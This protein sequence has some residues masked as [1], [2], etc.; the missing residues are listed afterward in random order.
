MNI[1]E[2]GLILSE[3]MSKISIDPAAGAQK[4]VENMDEYEEVHVDRLTPAELVEFSRY[5]EPALISSLVEQ[6]LIDRLAAAHDAR[7]NTML[8]MFA[9]NGF[10]DCIRLFLEH[11]PQ[12]QET[13]LDSQNDEGNTPLH[14]ACISGQL[15]TCKLLLAAGA[16]VAIEN[17]AERTPICEAHKHQRSTML[18][19][20]EET[21][22]RKEGEEE[23]GS[24]ANEAVV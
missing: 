7:G 16:K 2:E 3:I 21:L 17:K 15:E 11:C 6:G 9:A 24:A 5:G 12:V 23:N 8:H 22:G 20:F 19:F 14:W 10:V 4:A 1:A 18:S 13:I